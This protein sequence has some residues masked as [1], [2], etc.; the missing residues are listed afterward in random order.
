MGLLHRLLVGLPIVGGLAISAALFPAVALWFWESTAPASIDTSI[1]RG[2]ELF[3]LYMVFGIIL[4][5][6]VLGSVGLGI[7]VS[8]RHW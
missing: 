3:M 1:L 8:R 2:V 7:L 6:P 5:S 4:L